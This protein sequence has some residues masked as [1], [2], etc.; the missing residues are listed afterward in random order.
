MV[1]MGNR[2][3][4]DCS[5]PM[6]SPVF[7]HMFLSMDWFVEGRANSYLVLFFPRFPS[8][9]LFCRFSHVKIPM[10][11]SMISMPGLRIQYPAT[12]VALGP[13]AMTSGCFHPIDC[14]Q[15]Q[16]LLR[17]WAR[18][19]DPFSDLLR[20]LAR[21]SRSDSGKHNRKGQNWHRHAQRWIIG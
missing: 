19:T 10:C 5:R 1:A 7:S 3:S 21:W 12:R 8:L 11:C 16:E 2:P 4:L 18:G 15:D 13:W 6:A 9:G 20:T 17:C 14:L